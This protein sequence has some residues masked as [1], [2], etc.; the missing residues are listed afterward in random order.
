MVIHESESS[1]SSESE[2]DRPKKK[3]CF[4]KKSDSESDKEKNQ[5]GEIL[6]KIK[7]F[8][9]PLATIPVHQRYTNTKK[10]YQ[11]K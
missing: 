4:V 3:A 6:N 11:N 9:V 10:G 8:G 2:D 1:E 5:K 7:K